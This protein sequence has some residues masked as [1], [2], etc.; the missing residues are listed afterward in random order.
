MNKDEEIAYQINLSELRS[1]LNTIDEDL[2]KLLISRFSLTNEIGML[3]QMNNQPIYDQSREL[4]I[5]QNL[6]ES[7]R[8]H[9]HY[10]D[11][12]QLAQIELNKMSNE[13][14][15]LFV[16]CIVKIYQEIMIQSKIS[17]SNVTHK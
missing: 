8:R 4:D 9:H 2:I 17:Q 11:D 3:K 5:I 10:S 12:T 1:Q 7:I 6:S 14:L 15:E 16:S 13:N